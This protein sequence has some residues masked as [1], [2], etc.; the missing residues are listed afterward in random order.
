[1]S[2]EKGTSP[3][4]ELMPGLLRQETSS[5]AKITYFWI[6]GIGGLSTKIFEILLFLGG[7]V[8]AV[9]SVNGI[10]RLTIGEVGFFEALIPI[11]FFLIGFLLVY[12][13]LALIINRSQFEVDGAY[14]KVRHS[15]LLFPGAARLDLSS[16]EIS[17][18]EWQKV[19]HVSQTGYSSGR[20]S[21]GYSATFEV[22]L[23]TTVG[24]TITL[25]SGI[26]AREYAFAIAGE[27][28]RLLKM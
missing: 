15:P 14:L 3:S 21:S 6:R 7:M 23:K 24:K 8:A 19:G 10:V 12:R 4:M 17:S 2:E 16:A 22:V 28:N 9:A 18:V 13:G 25:L 20:V 27:L 1:M 26:G 11:F 5:G